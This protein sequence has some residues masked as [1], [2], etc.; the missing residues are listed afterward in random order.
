M[1]RNHLIFSFPIFH[2]ISHLVLIM[3]CIDLFY[4][5]FILIFEDMM[6]EVIAIFV[7]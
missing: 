6:L 2:S 7:V 5:D 3:I 1:F 4:I